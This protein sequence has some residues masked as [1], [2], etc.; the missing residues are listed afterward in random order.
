MPTEGEQP[1]GLLPETADIGPVVWMANGALSGA[2]LVL[3]LIGARWLFLDGPPGRL[4]QDSSGMFHVVKP[5]TLEYWSFVTRSFVIGAFLGLFG[6]LIGGAIT[7]HWRR[8]YWLLAVPVFWGVVCGT[9]GVLV[10]ALILVDTHDDKKV[11]AV[12][13]HGFWPAAGGGAFGL[14]QVAMARPLHRL[15][16]AGK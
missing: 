8:G 6:G 11:A 5:S 4:R 14:I 9:L 15:F 16:A 2:I 3:L 10:G 12:L 1:R 13:Q 7:L